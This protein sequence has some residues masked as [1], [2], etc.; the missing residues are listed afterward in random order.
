MSGRDSLCD[1]DRSP[2]VS[3]RAPL[4]FRR[5]SLWVD[6]GPLNLRPNFGPH[7]H[8]DYI[9]TRVKFYYRRGPNIVF[10]SKDMVEGQSSPVASSTDPTLFQ[11]QSLCFW[12]NF[13]VNRQT[14]KTGVL[15][16]WDQ[17]F[18]LCDWD[19]SPSVSRRAPL[20]F[21]RESLWVDREDRGPR[22]SEGSGFW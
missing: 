13:S 15:L 1:W 9:S 21:R 11:R 8:S 17:I 19:K 3:R 4:I 18:F 20:I 10:F 6:G 16:T 2:S 5:E 7:V 14:E 22:M 12:K